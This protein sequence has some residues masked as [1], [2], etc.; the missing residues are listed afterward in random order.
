MP[1]PIRMSS[2]SNPWVYLIGVPVGLSIGTLIACDFLISNYLH[3]E[4]GNL[5]ILR[6][7]PVPTI[8]PGPSFDFRVE[9][10]PYLFS[11]TIIFLLIGLGILCSQ[12][13]QIWRQRFKFLIAFLVVGYQTKALIKLGGIDL[14]DVSVLLFLTIWLLHLLINEDRGFAISPTFFLV[15]TLFG[16]TL[17]SAVNGRLPSLIWWRLEVKFLVLFVLL[18][19]YLRD[20]ETFRYFIKALIVMTTVSSVIGIIQEFLYLEMGMVFVGFVAKRDLKLML[21]QTSLGP[22]L[23]VP[24]FFG[25]IQSF[26]ITLAVVSTI[27]WYLILSPG[28]RVIQ[29]RSL[30]YL[31]FSLLMVNLI[32][33]FSK[34]GLLGFLVASVLVLY[35]KKPSHALQITT[36]F[37]SIMLIGMIGALLKPVLFWKTVDKVRAELSY[38]EVKLRAELLQLSLTES[39]RRHPWIGV[40]LGRGGKYTHNYFN[41]TAHNAFGVALAEVGLVGFLL[42]SLVFVVILSRLIL[43]IILARDDET[44]AMGKFLLAGFVALLIHLQADPFFQLEFAR[45]YWGMVE[46]F[47]AAA[48]REHHVLPAA[49][50]RAVVPWTFEERRSV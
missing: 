7:I 26:A 36:A 14:G 43:S 31:S 24:A 35:L 32:L 4:I 46:G 42:Y 40:G 6:R 44:R 50:V 27:V 23:R 12:F 38:G 5:Y 47:A 33:T 20:R 49:P 13:E 25:T 15:F 34:G 39:M 2:R 1:E 16:A 28:L 8:G 29:R 30:L 45:L 17:F 10:V 9:E 37:A 22:F 41:W 11:G 21:E 48:L 3:L 18:S 19:Y